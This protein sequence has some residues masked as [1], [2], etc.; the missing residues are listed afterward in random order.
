MAPAMLSAADPP[1]LWL[2]HKPAGLVT[3]TRDEKDRKTVFDALPDALPRVVSVG[4]LKSL[5]PNFVAFPVGSI[6]SRLLSV[7]LSFCSDFTKCF[8]N[9]A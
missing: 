3:T 5:D 6:R 2:Y 1:R 8:T 4:R 7:M 9:I